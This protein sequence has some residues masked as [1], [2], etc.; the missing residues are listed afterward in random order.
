MKKTGILANF[1][2]K[3]EW[4]YTGWLS[5][6]FVAAAGVMASFGEFGLTNLS[7]VL[8]GIFIVPNILAT[9]YSFLVKLWLIL[10]DIIVVAI[11]LIASSHFDLHQKL[12]ATTGDLQDANLPTP[13]NACS[14]HTE[15]GD[16]TLIMGSNATIE[17]VLPHIIVE[18][19]NKPLLLV[20]R[21]ADGGMAIT[22]NAFDNSGKVISTLENNHF[23][24]N[25][26]N[27][28]RKSNP[29]THTLLIFDEKNTEEL[30]VIYVSKHTMSIS[31]T[32]TLENGVVI[33]LLSTMFSDSCTAYSGHAVIS[34]R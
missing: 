32:F 5:A 29:D 16:Y 31:G 30:R 6:F 18:Y 28:F 1:L 10:T 33:P 22:F 23:V 2:V 4:Q 8:A 14:Q 25:V 19:R 21:G 27:I 11:F 7:F 24:E 34:I 15:V 26:N 17:K 3:S 13:R 12:D 20:G 9:K